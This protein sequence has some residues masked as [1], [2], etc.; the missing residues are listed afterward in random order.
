MLLDAYSDHH[1]FFK[2]HSCKVILLMFW[3][4][5]LGKRINFFGRVEMESF[6]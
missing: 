1:G 6:I 5:L 3:L 2:A 4:K